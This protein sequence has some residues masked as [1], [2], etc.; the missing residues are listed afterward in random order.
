MRARTMAMMMMMEMT[1][2]ESR[3]INNEKKADRRR[4]RSDA[5]GE[6]APP[7]GPKGHAK[8]DDRRGVSQL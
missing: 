1:M 5:P 3:G 6:G 7:I 4:C 2:T 8:S